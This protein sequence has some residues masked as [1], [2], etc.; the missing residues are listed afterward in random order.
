VDKAAE[1]DKFSHYSDFLPW[2]V[3]VNGS[4]SLLPRAWTFVFCQFTSSPRDEA[5]DATVSSAGTTRSISSAII[6]II[7]IIIK[8]IYIA[9]FRHAPKALCKRK[10][11]C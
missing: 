6:I 1:I 9:P 8:E 2:A 4:S 11:K 7:I 3:I 10:V 5:S